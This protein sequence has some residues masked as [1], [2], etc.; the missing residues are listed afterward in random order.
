MSNISKTP[1]D[2]LIEK[3][4]DDVIVFSN[5][6]YTDALI[7]LTDMNQAVYDYDLMI[8]W[9]IKHEN[10]DLE[11][12]ADF[13]SYNDS[14]YCGKYYPVIYY[15]SYEEELEDSSDYTQIVFTR[16]ENLLNKTN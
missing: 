15:K 10:M 5:P 1:I 7:G 3:G 13:I 6:D 8:E 9:L 11:E 4:Y 2:I 14:F 16:I 12:A